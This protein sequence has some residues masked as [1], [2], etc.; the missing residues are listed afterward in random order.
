VTS[1]DQPA[2]DT[3]TATECLPAGWTWRTTHHHINT[4]RAV[5]D[6]ARAGD[7]DPGWRDTLAPPAAADERAAQ[8][9]SD[10]R[11]LSVAAWE[12]GV[13]SDWRAA[14]DA[15]YLVRREIIDAAADLYAATQREQRAGLRRVREATM[16]TG[17]RIRNAL[18]A[19]LDS[20][21][22]GLNAVTAMHQ[23]LLCTER[24]YIGAWYRA[25]LAAGGEP[26]DWVGWYSHRLRRRR[27]G[28]LASALEGLGVRPGATVAGYGAHGFGGHAF[29]VEQ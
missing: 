28:R 20:G 27:V 3:V 26:V 7:L 24:D 21:D 16:N 29:G 6:Q 19:Q 9:V 17:P 13:A 23:T 14:L 22:R 1:T 10:L 25:G 4:M 8:A 15:W 5:L 11:T 12:P 2:P 18:L